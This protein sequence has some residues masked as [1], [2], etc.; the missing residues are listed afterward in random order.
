M[1]K[2]VFIIYTWTLAKQKLWYMYLI[3]F[4]QNRNVGCVS[5][6]ISDFFSIF[7][8]SM[9]CTQALITQEKI[10]G[11]DVLQRSQLAAVLV[12]ESVEILAFVKWW[13]LASLRC[14]VYVNQATVL[15]DPNPQN[16]IQVCL[17]FWVYFNLKF[18]FVKHINRVH[19]N[20]K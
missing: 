16:V 19:H 12:V 7:S 17:K 11:M 15:Q 13:N 6:F 20:M 18:R 5:L 4:T 14:S 8:S 2:P 3:I 1:T 10:M 9:T